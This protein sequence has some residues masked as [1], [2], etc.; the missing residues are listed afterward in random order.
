M[1]RWRF[2]LRRTGDALTGVAYAEAEGRFKP[3]HL[4]EVRPDRCNVSV[5]KSWGFN[6]ARGPSSLVV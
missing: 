1:P 5:M 4:V 6:E 2:D 3:A